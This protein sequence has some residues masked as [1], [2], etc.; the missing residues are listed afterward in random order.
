MK[1]RSR[2]NNLGLLAED[3]IPI[4]QPEGAAQRFW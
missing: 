1:L 3:G 2:K 4:E